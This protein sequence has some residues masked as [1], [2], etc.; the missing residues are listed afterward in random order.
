MK[1][2]KRYFIT[3]IDT[4]IGKTIVSAIITQ[5]LEADY[6]KPIQAGDL[7]QSDS[8]KVASLWSNKRSQVHPETYRLHTPASPHH[9]ARIDGI[10]I[11]EQQFVVP[12]TENHLVVEGAGGLFVP[13]NDHYLIIDLIKNLQLPVLL[14]ASFYLGSINHTLASID[15]LQRRS[16]PIAGLLFNGAITPSSKDYILQYSQV[17]CLGQIPFLPHLNKKSIAEQALIIRPNLL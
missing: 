1:D 16:I 13:L 17:P 9:A 7:D 12:Q 10:I 15:A 8:L 11:N 6:W 4:N 2:P 14:V 3:G 5:A